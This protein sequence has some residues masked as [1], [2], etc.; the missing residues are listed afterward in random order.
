MLLEVPGLEPNLNVLELLL[1][2]F[3]VL[4]LFILELLALLEPDLRLRVQV[5]DRSFIEGLV[6]HNLKGD[7]VRVLLHLS[8]RVIQNVS[9]RLLVALRL[10][11]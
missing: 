8:C 10:L 6:V 7:V 3:E 2:F 4:E 5:L 1:Y 11:P 9:Y